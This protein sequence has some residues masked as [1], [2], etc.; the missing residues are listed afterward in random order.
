MND[1]Y[2]DSWRSMAWRPLRHVRLAFFPS[3]TWRPSLARI[4]WISTSPIY[5]RD[6]HTVPEPADTAKAV[7]SAQR[8]RQRERTLSSLVP[9]LQTG[10]VLQCGL[11]RIHLCRQAQ[12]RWTVWW[13]YTGLR[14]DAHL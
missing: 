9:A 7:N 10:H 11:V 6:L 8:C 1:T 13:A 2:I 12:R 14:G 3:F 4:D 5:W